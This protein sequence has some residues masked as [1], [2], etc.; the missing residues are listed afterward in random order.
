MDVNTE[1]SIGSYISSFYRLGVGFLSKEYKSYGIGSGQYQFLFLL[2]N[3]DG[4]SHDVITEKMAVDK[5][6]TTRA[7][8]KL[9]KEGYVKCVLN[10]QDKRKYKIFLTDKALER[11]DEILEVGSKWEKKLIDELSSEEVHNLK[12]ILKKISNSQHKH[13][14]ERDE[15]L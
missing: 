9:E 10:E 5:A 11:K 3:E 15:K 2:Y 4:I 14:F 12:N 1:Q 7:I 8:N 13:I 6:T